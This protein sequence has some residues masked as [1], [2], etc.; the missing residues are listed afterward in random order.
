[1]KSEFVETSAK[2]AL[3]AT[4]G[5]EA[6]TALYDLRWMIVFAVALIIA[7]FWWGVSESLKRRAE[8]RFSRAGR[9][10]CNKL[11]DYMTYLLLGALV[12][13][14]I[15]EPLGLATHTVTAAIGLGLGC[16]WEIDSIIGHVCAVHNVR[17]RLSVKRLL[18]ALI[19][20]KNK[21]LGTAIKDAA[22][23]KETSP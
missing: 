6:L 7:D 23:V 18:I 13:L 5:S 9:R 15:A 19:I 17:W 20:K 12:G 1:M 16:L 8:F 3:W 11:V 22:D 2:G 10:T 14:A 21:D 4:M